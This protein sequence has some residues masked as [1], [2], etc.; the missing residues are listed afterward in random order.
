MLTSITKS[1]THKGYFFAVPS[2][3]YDWWKIWGADKRF[4]CDSHDL[5]NIMSVTLK[6]FST[7]FTILNITMS[8]NLHLRASFCIQLILQVLLMRAIPAY[9][10]QPIHHP[11]VPD[12]LQPS[13]RKRRTPVANRKSIVC[14]DCASPLQHHTRVLKN[15]WLNKWHWLAWVRE[16]FYLL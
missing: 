2:N 6:L 9:S 5:V 3:R 14:T 13:C 16:T 8:M 15:I 1:E 10:F 12:K 7:W 11:T 4:D